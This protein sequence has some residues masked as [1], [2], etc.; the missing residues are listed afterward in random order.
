MAEEQAQEEK[1]QITVELDLELLGFDDLPLILEMVAAS[2]EEDAEVLTADIL[3]F[4]RMVRR[5]ITSDTS[6]LK[7]THWQQ[8]FEVF[9]EALRR[10][11]NPVQES[12]GKN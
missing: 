7:L 9:G 12:T 8:V 2:E 3:S 4:I 6:K 11:L 5:A 10:V 1:G